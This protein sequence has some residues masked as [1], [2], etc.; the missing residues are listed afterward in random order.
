[1]AEKAE[2]SGK[3]F[4][5]K[6]AFKNLFSATFLNTPLWGGGGEGVDDS[7]PSRWNVKNMITFL[8]ERERKNWQ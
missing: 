7:P 4:R 3:Y 1:M 8:S 6:L 5:L 2:K